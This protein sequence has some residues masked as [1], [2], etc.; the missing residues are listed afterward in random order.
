MIITGGNDTVVVVFL[1]LHVMFSQYP[2]EQ[3]QTKLNAD[4][5]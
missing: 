5:E 4:T 1:D 2:N 3:L